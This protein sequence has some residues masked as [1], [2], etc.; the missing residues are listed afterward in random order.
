MRRVAERTRPPRGPWREVLADPWARSGLMILAAFAL[1]AVA[2]PPLLLPEGAARTLSAV[3]AN[4][5]P[6]R[7]HPMG[8]D[9]I[10]TDVF[11]RY[12]DGARATLGI[13]LFAG[14]GGAL[15]G[16]MVGACAGFAGGWVDRVLMRSV[17]F[18]I[19][20]PKLVLLVALTAVHDLGPVSLGL[21]IA[22]V[23][24]PSLARIVRG[25]VV[26]I[27]QREFV[28]ALRSLGMSSRRILV[29]HVIPNVQ[30]PILVGAV[31]A[32]ANA[33]LIEAG[34]AFLGLGLDDGSW[35][36]LVRSGRVL[37]PHWWIGGFAGASLVLVVVALNLVADAVRDAFDPRM[38]PRR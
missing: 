21:F 37:F 18:F 11:D 4:E 38:E 24:W 19:A 14:L 25:D 32:V 16:V 6:S 2:G 33:L 35:G 3:V 23:Q 15:F 30:G 26:G 34:L 17:D 9:A 1:L 29:R 13:G 27:M 22:L 10:R 8:T 20:L 5:A 31:L 7:L 12:L 28:V 36:G